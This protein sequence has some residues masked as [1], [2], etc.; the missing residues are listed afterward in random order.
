MIV[1][2]ETPFFCKIMLKFY[3]LLVPLVVVVVL[4]VC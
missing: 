1:A 2:G 3:P 4:L